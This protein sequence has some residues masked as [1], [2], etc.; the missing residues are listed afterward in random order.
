MA[1]V[2]NYPTKDSISNG[3]QFIAYETSSGQVVKIPYSVLR[4]ALATT[5]RQ[6]TDTPGSYVGQFGK[7]LVVNST[8]TGLEFTTAAAPSAY[9]GLT[10]TPGSYTGQGLKQPRVNTGE[11]GIEFSDPLF[12]GLVDTPTTYVG[13]ASKLAKVNTG[14]TALEFSDIN[15]ID[16]ADTPASMGAPGQ[17]IKVNPGGTALEYTSEA[18][19]QLPDTPATYAAQGLKVAR[20]NVAENAIEFVDTASTQTTGW[21]LYQD[22]VYTSGAP[23]VISAGVTSDLPNNA[24]TI[25]D[26]FVPPGVTVLYDGTVITPENI[27][28]AYEIRIDFKTSN[29]NVSG[30]ADLIIDIGAPV[31]AIATRTF[32][33]PKG[34]GTTIDYSTTTAFYSLATFVTNGGTIKINSITGDTS[35]WDISYTIF[36]THKGS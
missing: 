29:N 11:T 6:L 10:D 31:G 35:V 18:F 2:G 24:A 22:D 33:F 27:G 20:V 19:I 4:E 9:L 1:D 32:S 30:L 34:A 5:F 36:R 25:I 16:L 21:A 12:T 23:F 28:D 8:E 14:E 3:D 7:T 15:F 13:Q 17:L 26:T